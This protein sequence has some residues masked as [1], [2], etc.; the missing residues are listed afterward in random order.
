MVIWYGG[1]A[2]KLH[3]MPHTTIFLFLSLSL[4]SNNMFSVDGPWRNS[5]I[6][7]DVDPKTSNDC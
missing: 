5:V 2:F 6:L 1:G 4:S 7:I 3:Q